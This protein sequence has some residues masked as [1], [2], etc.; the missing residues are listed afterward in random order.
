M[1]PHWTSNVYV[2][3]VD[4]T[5]ADA[6][7]LG[8]RVLVEQSDFPNVGRLA[9]LADPHLQAARPAHIAQLTDPQGAAF[10]LHESAG[11]A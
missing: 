2:D 10:A 1:P 7:L 8:G 4:K 5:A 11:A 3:D 6:R 9:V